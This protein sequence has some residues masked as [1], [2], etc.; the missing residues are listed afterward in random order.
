M[1]GVT[2]LEQ[3]FASA[4]DTDRM[5]YLVRWGNYIKIGCSVDP[6]DRLQRVTKRGSRPPRQTGEPELVATIPGSLA[7]E[8]WLHTALAGERAV[9]EWF[10]LRGPVA[11]LVAFAQTGSDRAFPTNLGRRRTKEM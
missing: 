10:H 4:L 7:V 11:D 5:V 3:E 9:G 8:A 1:W 6:Y 2:A